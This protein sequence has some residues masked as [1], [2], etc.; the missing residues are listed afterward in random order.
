MPFFEEK[1]I[2]V[3]GKPRKRLTCP[4]C[5][6]TLFLVDYMDLKK[7]KKGKRKKGTFGTCVIC[8]LERRIG[9]GHPQ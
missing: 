6:N 3:K 5:G 9:A 8:G 7:P 2:T 4:D 1:E